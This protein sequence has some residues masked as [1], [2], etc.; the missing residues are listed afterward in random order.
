[1][2]SPRRFIAAAT[3]VATVA[4][5]SVA[6]VVMTATPAAAAPPYDVTFVDVGQQAFAVALNRTG[7]RAYV[8]HY[9]YGASANDDS[10]AVLDTATNAQLNPITGTNDVFRLALNSDDTLY[11]S[12]NTNQGGSEGMYVIA[13]GGTTAAATTS[14]TGGAPTG[15]AVNS[16]DTSTASDDSIYVAMDNAA[17]KL[18]VISGA[19]NSVVRY[20]SVGNRPNGV[21]VNSIDDTIYVANG[22]GN[23]ISVINGKSLDDSIAIA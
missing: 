1:M 12:K 11:G 5:V 6:G 9:N 16:N 22:A 20:V 23:T 17:G 7:T 4:A 21:A 2:R 3:S 18:A 13:P 10:I 15:I 19:N 8:S 14:L